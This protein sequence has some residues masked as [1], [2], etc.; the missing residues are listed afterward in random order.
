[1]QISSLWKPRIREATCLQH[2][3]L[4]TRK[5][6]RS[7][8]SRADGGAGFGVFEDLLPLYGSITMTRR[9]LAS[10]VID[11]GWDSLHFFDENLVQQAFRQ[12]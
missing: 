11:S 6:P 3:H 10:T 4:A 2:Q 1:M 5:E 12:E 7:D 8:Q 9:G